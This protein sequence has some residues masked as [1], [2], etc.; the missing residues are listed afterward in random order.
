VGFTFVGAP[1]GSGVLTPGTNS[2]LLVVQTNSALFGPTLASVIDG[3][4]TT[5]GSFAPGGV[6]GGVPEPGCAVL[7]AIGLIGLAPLRRRIR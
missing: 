5:V 2:A 6:G 4:V 1:I 7:A 3:M